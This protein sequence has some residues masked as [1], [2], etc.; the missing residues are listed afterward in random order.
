MTKRRT[1]SGSS[2]NQTSKDHSDKPNINLILPISRIHT[3]V[4]I[5]DLIQPFLDMTSNH[6]Q[7]NP[8]DTLYRYDPAFPPSPFRY[9]PGVYYW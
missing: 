8:N 9:E 3:A 5:T 2:Q 1:L 6:P 4:S 7:P